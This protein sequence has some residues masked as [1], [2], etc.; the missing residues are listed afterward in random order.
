MINL[1]TKEEIKI[2]SE[3][4]KKLAKI[5]GALKKEIQ[6]GIKTKFLDD[7]FLKL[8]KEEK[9][10]PAFLNYNGFPAAICISKN[11]TIVH[12]IP[13][14]DLIASGDLVKLDIGL[15][16]QGFYA[17]M[18]DTIGVQEIKPEEEKLILA[19]REAFYNALKFLYPNNTLGDIGYAIE[20]TAKKYGFSVADKLTGHGIGRNLHEEPQ[21]LNTGTP[22]KG[23]KLQVGM[24]LAIEPM[25][26]LGKGEVVEKKDG[27]FKSKDNSF[28]AHYEHTVAIL[29][30]GPLILTQ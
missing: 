2:M 4:G 28:T 5:M 15:K 20:S 23:I 12:G 1:K 17:D 3:A 14:N 21:V 29:E 25:F 19:V 8:V 13:S 27:S 22:K 24:V 18:A 30:N 7:L 9:A 26:V 10:E 6:P 16:Y 11:E